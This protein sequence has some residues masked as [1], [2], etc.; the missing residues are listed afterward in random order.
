MRGP[1]S[2]L[3]GP[4]YFGEGI[5]GIREA[6]KSSRMRVEVESPGWSYRTLSADFMPDDL[7]AISL[8]FAQSRAGVDSR[9]GTR[10]QVAGQQADCS[11]QGADYCVGAGIGGLDL[12][13]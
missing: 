1:L 12:E 6:G 10:R 3:S 5:R 7:S 9:R 13:E 11:E 4:K 8:G 2:G